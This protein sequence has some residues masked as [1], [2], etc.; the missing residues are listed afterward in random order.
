MFPE[1]AHGLEWI[2]GIGYEAWPGGFYAV[3]DVL[4]V[5]GRA[6][7]EQ[8]G[9]GTRG[10]ERPG[11]LFHLDER[12]CEQPR[13]A[14]RQRSDFHR[15]PGYVVGI[16]VGTQI[17]HVKTGCLQHHADEVLAYVVEVAAYC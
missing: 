16:P 17:D 12:A 14:N 3:R 4:A 9:A 2:P 10:R 8:Y 13:D 1:D 7:A 15:G 5:H 11:H 6:A